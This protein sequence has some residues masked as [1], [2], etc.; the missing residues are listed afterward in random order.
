MTCSLLTNYSVNNRNLCNLANNI[1]VW[2]INID[3]YIANNV[4]FN[5]FL[6]TDE[7]ERSKKYKFKKDQD[8]FSATRNILRDILGKYLHQFPENI[9]I[10]YNNYGKPYVVQNVHFNVSHSDKIALFAFTQL[11][12]IGVDIEKIKFIP[13]S[14][15][16]AQQYF[17][18][19]E[20]REL[21]NLKPEEQ[22]MAFFNFW[23]RK[24]AFIKAIGKG[25][26]F[27]LDRFNVTLSSQSS[28][29][30]IPS[31]KNL[32]NNWTLYPLN[33]FENYASALV[34]D[35]KCDE[36]LIWTYI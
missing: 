27:P 24:E 15:E 14:I 8:R 31:N 21:M 25:L 7:L 20:I 4:H 3:K 34:V 13:N 28:K 1:H 26:S 30:S 11:G 22:I 36:L 12:S 5:N 23:T 35:G 6:S 17:S 2:S 32:Y 33:K 19:N 10:L 16:I 18:D 9:K 29:I